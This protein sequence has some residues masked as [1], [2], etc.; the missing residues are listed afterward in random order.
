MEK[1]IFAVFAHKSDP[2]RI[3]AVIG[4][5]EIYLTSTENPISPL[6]HS[7][8]VRHFPA[9]SFEDIISGIMAT[10]DAGNWRNLEVNELPGLFF[11]LV[12]KLG[13]VQ[14]IPV[15]KM[16]LNGMGTWNPHTDN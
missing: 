16:I 8:E 11:R 12:E 2:D 9:R 4:K 10:Q 6:K 13:L 5:M 7:F 14:L 1:Q 3:F 15:F